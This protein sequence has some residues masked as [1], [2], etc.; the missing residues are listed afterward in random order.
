MKTYLS[1][2]TATYL[3]NAAAK[4]EMIPDPPPNIIRASSFVGRLDEPLGKSGAVYQEVG[5]K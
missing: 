3:C 5:Y 2:G 1:L 4:P